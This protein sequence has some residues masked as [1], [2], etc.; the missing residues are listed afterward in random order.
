MPEAKQ[1]EQKMQNFDDVFFTMTSF[2]AKKLE[3][4]KLLGQEKNSKD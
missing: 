4:T 2:C 3:K 1:T